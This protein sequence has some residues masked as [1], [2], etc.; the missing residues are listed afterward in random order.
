MF[1][2][3]QIEFSPPLTAAGDE[4][5]AVQIQQVDGVLRPI[6]LSGNQSYAGNHPTIRQIGE[7]A[8]TVWLVA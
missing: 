5:G 4:K 8:G 2:E 6:D 7:V 3:K 1:L